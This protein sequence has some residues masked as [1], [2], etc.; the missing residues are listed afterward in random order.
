MHELAHQILPQHRTECPAPIRARAG[1]RCR[2]GTFQLN[3]HPAV[4]GGEV[5]EEEGTAVAKQWHKLP[6]L[7]PGVRGGVPAVGPRE[8]PETVVAAQPRG[9]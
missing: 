2:A 4:R 6:E 9:V 8:P 1:K 5:A 7:V 3:L